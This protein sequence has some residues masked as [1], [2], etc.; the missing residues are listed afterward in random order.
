MLKLLKMFG[1][2]TKYGSE[3]HPST[4]GQLAAASDGEPYGVGGLYSKAYI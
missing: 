1:Y 2:C 3:Y 4:E